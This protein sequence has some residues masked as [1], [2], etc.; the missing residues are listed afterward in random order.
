MEK[1]KIELHSAILIEINR[2]LEKF[3]NLENLNFEKFEF[4]FNVNELKNFKTED[5]KENGIVILNRFK[6]ELIK[7]ENLKYE[8]NN[9][10]KNGDL[11]KNIQ[12][13]SNK[14]PCLYYFEISKN[15]NSVFEIIKNFNLFQSI[16]KE[17][18]NSNDD[19]LPLTKKE[20]NK[21]T[22]PAIK[23]NSNSKDIP[24]TKCI[25]VG[26]VRQ[27]L[28]NRFKVHLGLLNNGDTAG[29][30]LGWWAFD[31]N[32]KLNFC[33]YIFDTDMKDFMDLFELA[34]SR[35]EKPLIGK[36]YKEDGITK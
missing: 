36:Y 11:K 2:Y 10:K 34:L 25:Y 23:Y 19:K 32:I 14:K 30:Q 4:E 24:E 1:E 20:K 15:E 9:F 28:I 21:R 8:Q 35:A 3:N 13:I 27:N 29:L 26:K 5:S 17:K 18:D 6:S 16:E 33:V 31:L 22:T 7:F 12:I